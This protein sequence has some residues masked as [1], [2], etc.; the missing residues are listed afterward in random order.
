MPPP[1]SKR[2]M[3]A[4]ARSAQLQTTRASRDEKDWAPCGEPAADSASSPNPDSENDGLLAGVSDDALSEASLWWCLQ[5]SVT[6][7]AT[8]WRCAADQPTPNLPQ[9]E[10]R[11]A[12]SLAS[13]CRGRKK[14]QS[15]AASPS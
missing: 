4:R 6:T 5:P 14:S 15:K 8:F 9:G 1:V 3:H 13:F 10:S 2:Q 7:L 11:A 12:A